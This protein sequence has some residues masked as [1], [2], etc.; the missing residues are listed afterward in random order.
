[1]EGRTWQAAL[2]LGAVA[3]AVLMAAHPTAAH[4]PHGEPDRAMLILNYAVHGG[5]I[6]GAIL[7]AFGAAGL[8]ARLGFG[9]PLVL[10]ALVTFFFSAVGVTIAATLN[11]F[12][13]PKFMAVLAAGKMP[14]EHVRIIGSYNWWFNQ[15][16]AN[17][18]LAAS[19]TAILFWS[20]GWPSRRFAHLL[21]RAFGIAVG[22]GLP[23]VFLSGYFTMD[24]HGV[25]L[26]AAASGAWFI[27]A[28]LMGPGAAPKAA[29]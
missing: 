25:L 6:A 10:L 19:S 29:A 1:M 15:A 11:G 24:V 17:F 23:A 22:I 3:M 4:G 9:R 2:I 7:M 16:L 14:L 20:L 8:S 21:L 28:A 27:A 12:V 13:A 26:V 5:A 18:H